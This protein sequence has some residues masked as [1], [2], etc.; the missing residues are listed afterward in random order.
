[1]QNAGISMFYQQFWAFWF[2][3]IPPT[4]SVGVRF[5]SER[6]RVRIPSGP[7][8]SKS[9]T[10]WW[11]FYFLVWYSRKGIRTVDRHMPGAC[12][13]RQFKNWWQPLFPQSGNAANPF[14]ST[15]SLRTTYRSQRLFYK[16]H[17]SLILS[18]LLSKR[19]PLCWARVWFLGV[20]LKGNGLFIAQRHVVADFISF[21]TTF[22]FK[23]ELGFLT[24]WL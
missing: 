22:L 23:T 12:G 15:T 17:F 19:D 1:V 4:R 13:S 11:C 3:K 20:N 21:A 9:I 5:A 16:S 6:S 7:P 24:F 8:K 18:Q 14:R 2:G 10:F